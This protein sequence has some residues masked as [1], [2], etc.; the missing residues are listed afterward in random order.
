MIW[1]SAGVS[2]VLIIIM[3]LV[4]ELIVNWGNEY[5]KDSN[6][7]SGAI[8]LITMVSNGFIF[9]FLGKSIIYTVSAVIVTL[10]LMSGAHQYIRK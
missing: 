9:C 4:M 10:I 2:F 8:I 5:N 3:S 1:I 7:L 6:L